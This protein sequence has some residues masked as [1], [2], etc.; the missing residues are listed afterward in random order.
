[1]RYKGLGLHVAYSF[2]GQVML[3]SLVGII[4]GKMGILM[5]S[6]RVLLRFKN[7]Q[8]LRTSIDGSLKHGSY[9]LIQALH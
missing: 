5:P 6:Y 1:M 2:H 4:A 9:C 7:C 3:L 8:S